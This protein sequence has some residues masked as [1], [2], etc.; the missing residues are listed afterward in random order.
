VTHQAT[1]IPLV[2]TKGA[3]I[4]ALGLKTATKW[5]PSEAEV[6][7]RAIKSLIAKVE[8]IEVEYRY[9]TMPT[10]MRRIVTWEKQR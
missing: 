6:N 4:P 9:Q 10:L 1:Y 7:A 3:G 2:K 8:T 5:T